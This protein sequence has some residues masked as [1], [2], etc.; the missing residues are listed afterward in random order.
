MK[1]VRC[2]IYTRKSSEEGLEQDFNSLDAQREA[3][4]AYVL[5]QASEGWTAVPDHYDD[6]GISGGTL[7][8]P[9]LQR[10]LA[11]IASGRID[12]VVVYKVDR[13]TRSLL[14]FSKLVEAFDGA[15]VSF[16]SVTQS[17][18]TTTSMGRLTLNMLLSFAQFEREVT[19]ERIRDKLAASKAKGMW[20]GGVP[21]LGYEPDGR[22]LKIVPEHAGLIRHIY[23][24]YLALGNVRLLAEDLQGD[25]ICVPAR[26]TRSG[27]GLGGVPF[28]KGY[29]YTVL[30]SP[31]YVGDIPHKE[32]TYPGLHEAIIDRDT[33]ERVQARL[34]DQTQGEQR[35][36]RADTPSPLAGKVVDANGAG[37]IASHATKGM[38]RYRYYIS[39]PDVPGPATRVPAV[40]LEAAVVEAIAQVLDDPLELSARA[41]FEITPSLLAQLTH[42]MVELSAKLR[43][44]DHALLR[45]LVGQVRLFDS[46]IEISCETAALAASLGLEA[47]DHLAKTLELVSDARLKRSGLAMR[48]VHENGAAASVAPSTSLPKLISRARRW[49]A[50]L[51]EGDLCIAELARREGV[52][53]S[54][55]TRLV[56]LA[57]LAPAVVDAALDGT[58]RAGIDSEGLTTPGVIDADWSVQ[59]M[60]LLPTR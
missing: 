13:L 46:R 47:N 8:R 44:R 40:E 52:T 54:Y 42:K 56:R 60:K 10:L 45:S 1:S 4:A 23:D 5:S 11:D 32:R 41:G 24:R 29:L 26:S 17:F 48:F 14:D 7:E 2:A 34:A 9:A 16:V 27:R 19:A 49:W 18:N 55:M 36:A 38:R 53:R 59:Q 22:T 25:S 43:Q 33:W 28:G 21:P 12:I 39:R 35:G 37:L 30:K 51:R 20:M 58:L 6:G 57:F 15:G 3:C 50:I 31:I